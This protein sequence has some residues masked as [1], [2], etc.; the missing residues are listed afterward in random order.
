MGA[1]PGAPKNEIKGIAV[2]I[3]LKLFSPLSEAAGA[4]ELSLALPEPATL[5]NV[6]EA[7]VVRFGEGMKRHLYDL[8]G[9]VIPSWAVFLNNEVIPMNRPGALQTKIVAGDELSFI[10]NIAGG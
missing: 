2:I 7:L 10:L 8:D 9:R 4:G 1:R 5:N 3:R 6:F